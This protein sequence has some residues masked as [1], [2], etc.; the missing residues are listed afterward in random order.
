MEK[1]RPAQSDMVIRKCSLAAAVLSLHTIFRFALRAIV[2]CQL[3]GFA[4]DVMG[5][6]LNVPTLHCD[7]D[8][9]HFQ[10]E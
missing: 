7:T 4:A 9:G 1:E 10:R 8:S 5:I 6:V 2:A 3:G